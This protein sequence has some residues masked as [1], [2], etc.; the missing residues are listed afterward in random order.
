MEAKEAFRLR[1]ETFGQ[2]CIHAIIVK[3][4]DQ[5]KDIGEWV[6][7]ECGTEFA[8]WDVWEKINRNQ[9]QS[10]FTSSTTVSM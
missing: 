7:P 6:C 2:L 3:E 1:R 8:K 10:I 5:G 4:Y 9:Q